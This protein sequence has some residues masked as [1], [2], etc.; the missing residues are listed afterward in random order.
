M[1]LTLLILSALVSLSGT[2]RAECEKILMSGNDD[3]RVE[4][5]GMAA[6]DDRHLTR[7]EA[8][9]KLDKYEM[10][11]AYDASPEGQA[12]AAAINAEIEKER[13]KELVHPPISY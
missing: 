11:E 1:K 8:N 9:N 2:A 7:E 10:W 3:Y 4:C 13:A 5:D 6:Q 12:R